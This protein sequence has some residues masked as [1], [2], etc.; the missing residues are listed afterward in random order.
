M[1][2]INLLFS[3]S[4]VLLIVLFTRHPFE[5]KEISNKK[6]LYSQKV[7]KQKEFTIAF[8]KGINKSIVSDENI[9]VL[10]HNKNQ[11]AVTVKKDRENN[12]IISPPEKG[13]SDGEHYTLHI[14]RDLDLENI[15]NKL[16]PEEYIINFDVKNS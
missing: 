15:G 3:I 5:K 11:V 7:D 1:K 10:D 4:A 2:K 12:V 16:L 13:Y 9:Y 14:N 8:D 6:E